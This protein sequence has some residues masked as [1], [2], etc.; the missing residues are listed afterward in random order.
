MS[1]P[2]KAPSVVAVSGAAA[3]DDWRPIA[4]AAQ[5]V[6]AERML[7]LM[8]W[9]TIGWA[10]L[11]WA[12]SEELDFGFRSAA[13]INVWRL[14]TN[15]RAATQ[16]GDALRANEHNHRRWSLRRQVRSSRSSP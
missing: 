14:A 4:G 13:I 6:I 10:E 9:D 8:A 1:T 2:G 5:Q 15:G 16:M 7:L 11:A 3:V 12:F